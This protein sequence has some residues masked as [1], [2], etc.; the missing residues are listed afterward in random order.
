MGISRLKKLLLDGAPD[1]CELLKH[2]EVLSELARLAAKRGCARLE[3]L[4]L[5]TAKNEMVRDFY[6]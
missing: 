4:S 5:P 3:G 6:A 2:Q 1:F